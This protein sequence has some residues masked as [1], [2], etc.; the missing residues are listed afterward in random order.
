MRDVKIL[1]YCSSANSTSGYIATEINELGMQTRCDMEAE[2]GRILMQNGISLAIIYRQEDAVLIL[3]RLLTSTGELPKDFSRSV[4]YVN[5]AF[6]FKH[7]QLDQLN[8]LACYALEEP[9]EA[10]DKLCAAYDHRARNQFGYSFNKK[11]IDEVIAYAN[12]RAKKRMNRQNINF[13]PAAPKRLS[14]VEAC[15]LLSE[16]HRI[17]PDCIFLIKTELTYD[18]LKQQGFSPMYYITSAENDSI[19]NQQGEVAPKLGKMMKDFFFK[20]GRV[21][22]RRIAAVVIPVITCLCMVL[23]IS[24][25]SQKEKDDPNA[26]VTTEPSV[27]SAQIEA[28]G[29]IVVGETLSYHVQTIGGVSPY[30]Y[31]LKL[32]T[33][34]GF[35]RSFA[36]QDSPDFSIQTDFADRYKAV[37]YVLDGKGDTCRQD[38]YTNVS[39]DK[40]TCMY[41][42]ERLKDGGLS[43]LAVDVVQC[44][45]EISIPE[46]IEGIPVVHIGSG[47]FMDCD[48]L[49]KVELPATLESI[50]EGAFAPKQTIEFVYEGDSI[51]VN[52]YLQQYGF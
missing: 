5:L 30:R 33:S 51:R 9:K 50:D 26:G 3:K 34:E 43:I 45:Q 32:Y 47:V 19:P 42:T 17:V 27:L 11:Q 13:E 40:T 14:E 18:R 41:T 10:A 49:E 8:A 20:G 48:E 52:T 2:L 4:I 16:G 37:I 36:Y 28:P 39:D 31:S 6:K 29:E 24:S 21:S 44:G 12:S 38:V 25:F 7:D 1:C 46:K 23:L 35:E 15:Q 22:T